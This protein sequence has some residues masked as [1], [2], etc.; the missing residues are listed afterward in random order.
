LVA[1]VSLGP[2]RDITAVRSFAALKGEASGRFAR[3]IP[4][5]IRSLDPLVLITFV[6]AAVV[7]AGSAMPSAVAALGETIAR[8]N[9]PSVAGC[10]S[11]WN[12]SLT[13]HLLELGNEPVLIAPS[14]NRV[15]NAAGRRMRLDYCTY[16][17]TQANDSRIAVV[18]RWQRG[19][20]ASWRS[21]DR[22]ADELP[23][24]AVSDPKGALEL[25]RRE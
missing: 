2:S 24:N 7:I 12:H 18:G 1:V 6:T 5:P 23:T 19:T 9:L 13:E 14:S 16:L 25:T 11:A 15:T 21:R 20:I 22:R 3:L 4:G 8:P 10:A 17:F